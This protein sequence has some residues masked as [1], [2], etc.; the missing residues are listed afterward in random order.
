MDSI[1]LDAAEVMTGIS[2]RTLWRRVAD[3]ALL[4]TEKDGRGRTMLAL[5]GLLEPMQDCTGLVFSAQDLAVLCQADAGDA[6][7]QADVGAQLYA[8]SSAR[9]APPPPSHA[10]A[11]YW[12]HLAAEQGNCD[13]MH[14]LSTAAAQARTEKGNHEALMWLAKAAAHGHRIAQMQMEEMLGRCVPPAP[15]R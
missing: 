5:A 8:A 11:L 12:L 13:A 3:G 7:A 1:S 14:W 6:Q 4:S 2:R 9:K 15:L 10:A